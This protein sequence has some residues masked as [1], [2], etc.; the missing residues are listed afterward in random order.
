M[1]FSTLIVRSLRFHARAH[2]GTLL[3]AAVGS[4]VLIG[5]LVVGDSVRESLR[6]MALQRLGRTEFALASNDRF[7]REKLTDDL[8]P[9]L[10]KWGAPVLQIPGIAANSDGSARA[11]RVQILGVDGRF[12]APSVRYNSDSGGEVI[13]NE[14]LAAHLNV[15]VGET[16]LLRIQKPSLLSRDVPLASNKDSSIV[17]RMKVRA[18]ASDAEYGRF[19][20]QANETGPFN[21]FVPLK[22]LQKTLQEEGRANLLLLPVQVDSFASLSVYYQHTNYSK[23]IPF[24]TLRN[25]FIT[26]WVESVDEQLAGKVRETVKAEE[27]NRLVKEKWTLSDLEL[28]ERSLPDNTIEIRSRR[29]FIDPPIIEAIQKNQKI[30]FPN[31]TKILT[32]FV[33]ELRAGDRST[34]YS[35]V[36][37]IENSIVP[38]DLKDDEIVI[39]QWL[40]DDLQAKPGDE[41]SLKYF[42]VR[43]AG[44]LDEQTNRFR[45]HSIL[46]LAGG[47]ADRDLMPDFPGLA[48][49]ESSHDWD[50]G[51]PI[52][53]GKIRDKDEKYWKDFRG[54]PKAFVTL[55]AGQKMWANRFG[56]LTA[57]RFAN[58]SSNVLANA[59]L[60]SVE[61]ASLGLSFQPVREQA[62]KA[63]SESEDFGGLFLGFSFFLIIAALILMSLLFQF[64]LEQRT[65]ETGLL[66]ALGFRPRQVRRLLLLEGMV[67]AFVGGVL[68]V[69]GGLLFA[70]AMLHG[71][72]TVWRPAV[73][74]SALE[75]HFTLTTLVIGLGSSVVVASFTIWLALRNQAKRPVHELLAQG[76]HELPVAKS[77]L[78][79]RSW[80]GG[81][82][83][84]SGAAALALI[85]WSIAKKETATEAFFGGGA[86]LLIAG[87]A[88]AA[89]F[90]KKLAQSEAAAKLSLA[91]M[92]IRSCTRRRKRSLATIALLACGSFLVVAVGANKLSS[93]QDKEKRSAGTGGFALIGES[94]LPIVQNLNDKSGRDFFGLDE[95]I[96]TGV[97]FVPFRVHDGDDA[98]CLNLNRAQSPRLLGVKAE[99]LQERNA[100]TFSKIAEGSKADKPWLL[101]KTAG[102]GQR[103]ALQA[104]EIPAIGDAA[105]IQWALH[106]KVGD[107]L[108][109]V[110]ERGRSFKVRIVGAVRNSILQG[111]LIVDEDELLR[112]Y[113]SA[114]GYRMFLID[115]PSKVVPEVSAALSRA[116]QD[117]GF[118][119]KPAPERLA[120]FNAVQNTYLSTFQ[121]LGGLGLL[122]GSAGLGVVVLRNVLE[123]RGE[124]ALLLAVGFR[125][126]ALRRLVLSE[127]GALLVAGLGVGLVAALVAVLPALISPGTEIPY[128][129]LSLT[130]GAILVSGIF[131]TYLAARAALRG[132][133]LE[134]LRN[135]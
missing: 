127:H 4:A 30:D 15:K 94:T 62:L 57:I 3:G 61:P 43:T 14:P 98:S 80:S 27:F 135:E 23:W 5:A 8:K 1:K 95:K 2:L 101:L 72:K 132:K 91:G 87:L 123:R 81:I 126:G 59:I 11:N 93:T 52:D 90:L 131:W 134:A 9:N 79:T 53:L 109:Y 22:L 66:L 36:T 40:A 73:G 129:S 106:K 65:T 58:V 12:W 35:M 107:T 32:Y 31:A 111:S 25:K 133:L 50:T 102:D 105:S 117:V 29:V 89:S 68:G 92:G 71:L 34:P 63:A 54:T 21:A 6:T 76:D 69:A 96:L 118:E 56:D 97:S 19:S 85:G 51:F 99:S 86:L 104:D 125:K 60:K 41:L 115:A 17:L 88:G 122:L 55:A 33:N 119:V 116:L 77:T 26:N 110:D 84:A 130:L 113:P 64:G 18:I 83:L 38:K 75:F 114:S 28:E 47:T 108:D 120:A 121:I 100:F 82:A 78:K 74:T 70:K 128:L 13:L 112:R 124:L 7:F 46:P 37:A 24:Q 44:K 10:K 49:A 67:I 103:P 16:I 45:I 20:L 42:V 48:K 39:N